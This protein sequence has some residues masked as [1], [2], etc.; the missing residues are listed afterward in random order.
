VKIFETLNDV[1]ESVG[2]EIG[3][4]EWVEISQDMINTFA[5]V[6][7]DEQW[8]HVDTERAAT[9]PFGKTIAHGFL[10]VSLIPRLVSTLY[11]I[12][13]KSTGVNYGLNKVRFMT[14]IPSGS[15]IR[16][17]ATLKNASEVSGSGIQLE[18]QLRVEIDGKEKPACLAEW[19]IRRYPAA[20]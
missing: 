6:T 15:R 11:Q 3:P 17:Y 13:Q 10:T 1:V 12:R 5:A 14:P 16:A 8:I 20:D 4:S 2:Q 19:L 7:G 18:W 9:G